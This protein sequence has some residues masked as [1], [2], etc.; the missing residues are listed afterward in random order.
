MYN[1]FINNGSAQA[2]SGNGSI[3]ITNGGAIA[4]FSDED[5][6]FDEDRNNARRIRHSS[7]DI[8]EEVNIQYNYFEYLALP[9]CLG[10]SDGFFWYCSCLHQTQHHHH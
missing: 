3:A 4:Q 9:V 8:P 2:D 1:R 10:L 5:V 6:E 7:R